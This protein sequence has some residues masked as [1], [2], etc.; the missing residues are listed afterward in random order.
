MTDPKASSKESARPSKES[1]EALSDVSNNS[2]CSEDG[3]NGAADSVAEAIPNDLGETNCKSTISDQGDQETQPPPDEQMLWVQMQRESVKGRAI[4]TKDQ[5]ASLVVDA[6]DAT[7]V[8]NRVLEVCATHRAFAIRNMEGTV[9]AWGDEAWGG[10]AHWGQR[11]AAAKVLEEEEE[12]PPAQIVER[13]YATQGAFAAVLQGGSVV[14]WGH[15]NWG[16]E[17]HA[18]S[19]SSSPAALK[20]Q[21][22]SGVKQVF[23]TKE[24][25]A[26]LKSK[27]C[28]ITWGASTCG[29]D[30]RPVASQLHRGVKQ[31]FSTHRAFAALK[32]DG[33]VVTWGRDNW[34]G[35]SRSV[36]NSICSDVQE[37]FSTQAAFAA[38]K[39][40]HSVVTWGHEEW[41]GS[42]SEVAGQLNKGSVDQIFS[43]QYGFIASILF[44]AIPFPGNNYFVAVGT[45]HEE[46]VSWGSVICGGCAEEGCAGDGVSTLQP[47]SSCILPRGLNRVKQI[48]ATHRACAALCGDGS[49]VA[50]GHPRWGGDAREVAGHL[51]GAFEIFATQGSQH[52]TFAALCSDGSVVT[53][54]G[55]QA[56]KG[57]VVAE[58]VLQLCCT[59]EAF[60]ALR[61]DG[62]VVTWGVDSCGG[63]S[64]SV[65]KQLI[66]VEEIF[67][68]HYA[69][70]ALRGDGTLV[71]WGVSDWGGES[72]MWAERL[73][74]R[75]KD[76]FGDRLTVRPL[77]AG[78]GPG[79]ATADDAVAFLQ[80]VA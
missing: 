14:T 35:D 18:G 64:S 79:P 16:G 6:E 19:W 52:G 3:A 10:D 72:S 38:L 77:S 26:A 58:E 59:K 46:F 54:G 17:L 75:A 11:I 29:G 31:I 67:A 74:P 73:R 63:D 28:V 56:P 51:R 15:S 12:A 57:S 4:E 2:P 50:W 48:V 8:A 20:E 22:K 7:M 5:R 80:S 70:A 41:G 39:A 60:A 32:A 76:R 30:S 25:F 69:F 61:A 34:G 53:W 1:D 42:S 68:T 65:A 40:D 78:T 21:L 37:I 13:L 49:V 47:S 9:I 23:S 33:S 43:L 36:A 62:T 44:D 71:T 55:Q 45:K 24:A 66:Y 27:G